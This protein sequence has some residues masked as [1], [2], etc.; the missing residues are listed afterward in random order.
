MLDPPLGLGSLTDKLYASATIYE[1]EQK[2]NQPDSTYFVDRRYRGRP[3]DSGYSNRYSNHYGNRG[4]HYHEHQGPCD[5]RRGNKKRCFICSNKDCRSW[6]HP[7]KEQDEER[8]RF[9]ADN[10]TKFNTKLPGFEGRFQRQYK[11]YIA[12]FEGSASSRDDDPE[13][14]ALNEAFACLL[15]Q[16]DDDGSGSGDVNDNFYTTIDGA[17]DNYSYQMVTELADRA[18]IHQLTAETPFLMPASDQL[19]LNL[20]Q[21]I[22]DRTDE[23][24]DK[25]DDIT[26]RT[27]ATAPAAYHAKPLSRYTLNH[28]YGILVD[29]GAAERSTGGYPQF[30][31]LQSTDKDLQMDESTKGSVH[32]RFGIGTASSL[33]S[34][35]M[36]TPIGTVQFHIFPSE[37]PFLLCLADM[38]R[39]GVY[40]NNVSN[41]LVGPR[42]NVPVVRR[43]GHP[44]LLWNSSLESFILESFSFLQCFLTNI[45]LQ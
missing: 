12:S 25:T 45:E 38:D 3:S 24:T 2:L 7:R 15:V 28:F 44:F 37:T 13:D 31:A 42:G 4:N 9:K 14:D 29:T 32:V 34:I 33:G 6:K 8:A 40:F 11:Q 30:Q 20:P 26:D 43:Y 41:T 35:S 21:G 5:S 1:N 18:F 36:K 10:L 16:Q 22:T 27:D 17:S 23:V 19:Q 39:L